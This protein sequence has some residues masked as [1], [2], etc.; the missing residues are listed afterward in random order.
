MLNL[1]GE[2]KYLMQKIS[3]RDLVRAYVCECIEKGLCENTLPLF[4]LSLLICTTCRQEHV[5]LEAAVEG[6][7]IDTSH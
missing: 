5:R 4:L 3:I 2:R 6:T 7:R 1:L